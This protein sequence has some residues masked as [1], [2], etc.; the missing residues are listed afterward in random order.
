LPATETPE[1]VT[2]RKEPQVDPSG[3]PV[4]ADRT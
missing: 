4:G 2:L 3:L 1:S